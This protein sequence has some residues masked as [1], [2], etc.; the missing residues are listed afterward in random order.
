MND[1]SHDAP[2]N[3]IE[4][5]LDKPK[6]DERKREDDSGDKLITNP[7]DKPGAHDNLIPNPLDKE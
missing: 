6:D 4:N 3:L 2:D 1:T 5:P 7:L